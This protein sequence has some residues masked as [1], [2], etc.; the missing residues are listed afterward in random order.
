MEPLHFGGRHN[1]GT[2]SLIFAVSIIAET[3]LTDEHVAPHRMGFRLPATPSA[4]ARVGLAI[5]ALLIVYASLYP[6]A[7]W[8]STG[9]SPF[10]YLSAPFPY[11]WTGFDVLTNIAGYAPLGMLAVLAMYPHVRGVRAVVLAFAA[12]T[13]LSGTMETVQNY[14]P[15]R[16][17]SNLD[18]IANASGALLGALAALASTRFFM[19]ESRLLFWRERWFSPEASRGIVVV[20][21]WPLAQIYPLD[22]LFGHG[23]FLPIVS[24]WLGNWLETPIDLGAMLRSSS[25]LSVEQYW[26]AE[27]VISAC[28]LTGA[29]LALLCQMRSR[30]P[31]TAT[32]ILLVCCAL[33]VRSLA[34]ALEFSPENAFAWLTPGARGGMLFGLVMLSGLVFAPPAAQR[35]V[36]ALTLL[37]S[38]AVV[39]TVPANP[40]FASTLQTWAQGKFINFNGAAQFLSLLWPFIALWF[41]FHRVHSK[42]QV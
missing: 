17:P 25:D 14:L 1:S 35:R 27:T 24:D 31:K 9:L 18:L 6:F 28:G 12:C 5:Y 34:S 15:S 16:V 26:L 41:L 22:Y 32:A 40:Y 36:A 29:V 10:E 3:F 4:F 39:N 8:R 23:Q 19:E 30:A 37:M 20:A 21:L 7:G 38:M 13:L 11:Y 2:V 33:A 42:K